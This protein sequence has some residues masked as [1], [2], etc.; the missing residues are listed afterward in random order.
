MNN[1]VK[2]WSRWTG[3]RGTTEGVKR[4]DKLLDNFKKNNTLGM[5]YHSCA[6]SILM[7]VRGQYDMV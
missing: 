1:L 2:D 5:F 4:A 3:S 7:T 6:A